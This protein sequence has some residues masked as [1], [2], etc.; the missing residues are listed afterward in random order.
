LNEVQKPA[1]L[2]AGKQQTLIG[3]GHAT[4]FT[5]GHDHFNDQFFCMYSSIAF[6][7]AFPAPIASMTVAAPDTASPPA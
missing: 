1:L 7:A 2:G 4:R 6:A 5:G 3:L